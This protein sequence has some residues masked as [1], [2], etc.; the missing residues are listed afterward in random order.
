MKDETWGGVAYGISTTTTPP[1]PSSRTRRGS[2]ATT[3][4]PAT[5][6]PGA[7]TLLPNRATGCS[8]KAMPLRRSVP[9]PRQRHLL[10]VGSHLARLHRSRDWLGSRGSRRGDRRCRRG[11]LAVAGGFG[12]TLRTRR[13][14]VQ[15]DLP[16]PHVGDHR[17]L[18]QRGR[19]GR[20]R[21]SRTLLGCGRSGLFLDHWRWRRLVRCW[22]RFGLRRARDGR[23]HLGLRRSGDGRRRRGRGRALIF[24]TAVGEEQPN[25]DAHGQT[26]GDHH[27]QQPGAP[28]RLAQAGDHRHLP[29]AQLPR[30][31]VLPRGFLAR[32]LQGL[33]DQAHQRPPSSS[34]IARRTCP[35]VRRSSP[36][37]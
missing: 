33:V 18:F 27:G 17:L 19:R 34:R 6:S 30:R 10:L 5:L 36:V 37:T 26:R 31:L 4:K 1:C 16:L 9:P 22:S 7:T 8:E 28:G 23:L 20:R 11:G 35:R 2:I 21:R 29:V 25:P 15:R 13:R 12:L 14:R 32:P 24:S 3:L